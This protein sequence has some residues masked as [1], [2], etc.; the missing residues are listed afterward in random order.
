MLER[1]FDYICSMANSQAVSH[2]PSSR[3]RHEILI[4]EDNFINQKV[5]ASM[6][7]EFGLPVVIADNGQAALELLNE[8]PN[9]CFILMDLQMP[10]MDGVSCARAIRAGQVGE[11]YQSIPIVAL[12]ANV[13]DEHR[14]ACEDV[15]M[16]DFIGKPVQ[17]EQF[18]TVVSEYL[19]PYM[20]MP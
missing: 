9:V 11:Q 14:Q 10:I 15:G 18:K 20:S 7:E 2:Q 3:D 13:A 4:V 8:N 12:T 19:K 6:L 1:S 17:L 16:N 5:A